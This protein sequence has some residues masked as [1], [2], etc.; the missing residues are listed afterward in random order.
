MSNVRLHFSTQRCAFCFLS[1]NSLL[2]QG[3]LNQYQPNPGFDLHGSIFANVA[4]PDEE[5][6][7]EWFI[8]G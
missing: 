5:T 1:A 7:R 2:G 3:E 8:R 4:D 6:L